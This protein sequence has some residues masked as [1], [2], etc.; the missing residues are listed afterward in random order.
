MAQVSCAGPTLCR[1]SCREVGIKEKCWPHC[2]GS[3]Y[4]GVSISFLQTFQA[5]A[6]QA[7]SGRSRKGR[8]K[9]RGSHF[10][11]GEDGPNCMQMGREHEVGP[12]S[13]TCACS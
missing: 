5:S 12:E 11:V 7:R 8:G 10:R 4:G 6:F 1:C 2:H 13:N 3:S 9:A